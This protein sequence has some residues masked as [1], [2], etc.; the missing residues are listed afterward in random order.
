MFAA[1][2]TRVPAPDFTNDR[3][4]FMFGSP[5]AACTGSL[6]MELIVIVFW[7]LYTTSS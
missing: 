3:V 1:V 6:M 4:P 2:S 5:F 7:L